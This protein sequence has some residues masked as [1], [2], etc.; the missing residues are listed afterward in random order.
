MRSLLTHSL[1]ACFVRTQL[2]E[3][4]AQHNAN[5]ATHWQDYV[6]TR[7]ALEWMRQNQSGG[8]PP[9]DDDNVNGIPAATKNSA[10]WGGGGGGFLIPVYLIQSRAS[11]DDDQ[12]R[13][14]FPE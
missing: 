5:P 9:N 10:S 8:V 7:L 11:D 1:F 13:P 12:P 2:I 6:P 14:F 3:W 4:N